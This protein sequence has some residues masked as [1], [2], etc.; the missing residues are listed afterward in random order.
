MA[1]LRAPRSAF[2][3][4]LDSI[5]STLETMVFTSIEAIKRHFPE[6][7]EPQLACNL[8]L[9]RDLERM[10]EYYRFAGMDGRLSVGWLPE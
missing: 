5:G 2:D 8:D 7:I 6:G 10:D 4:R 1:A 9:V 3:T